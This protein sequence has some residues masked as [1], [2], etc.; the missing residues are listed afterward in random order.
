MAGGDILSVAY[1]KDSLEYVMLSGAILSPK[2]VSGPRHRVLEPFMVRCCPREWWAVTPSSCMTLARSPSRALPS[3]R[4][5]QLHRDK[6]ATDTK[7]YVFV[8]LADAATSVRP[9]Y[10]L[11]VQDVY[12]RLMAQLLLAHQDLHMLSHVEDT[13]LT[14]VEGLCR[15][16]ACS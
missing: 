5:M 15:I 12:T 10:E 14:K 3:N 9:D 16:A 1:E 11:P 6:L 8:G 2:S 7:V 4:L 13:G